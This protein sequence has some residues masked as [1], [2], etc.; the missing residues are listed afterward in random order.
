MS[1][2][3]LTGLA[4]LKTSVSDPCMVNTDPDQRFAGIYIMQITIVGEGGWPMEKKGKI[5]G[6]G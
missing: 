6:A 2:S 5:K 1:P 4:R 3:D